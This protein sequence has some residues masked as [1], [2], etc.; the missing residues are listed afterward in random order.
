MPSGGWNEGRKHGFFSS[1]ANQSVVSIAVDEKYRAHNPEVLYTRDALT[2]VDRYEIDHFK[3]LSSANPRKRV[4][5]CAHA[6]PA[7][8]LHEMVIIHERGAYVRPHKHPGKT[9]STHVIEGLVDVVV[10]AD[11]GQIVKVLPVGDYASGRT[12]YYRMGAPAFHTLLIRSEVLVFHEITN[13]PFDRKDTVFAPWAP[14]DHDEE[15]IERYIAEL[16]DKVRQ[17]ND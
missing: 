15:G 3:Q 12:F 17:W 13:G 14:A 4:R 2:S 8:R 7:D 16:E 1:L 5:L 9:E 11:D 10:F 6:D